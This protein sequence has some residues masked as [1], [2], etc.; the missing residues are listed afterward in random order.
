MV[1][2]SA[3]TTFLL[4]GFEKMENLKYSFFLASF[5]LYLLILFGNTSLITVIVLNENLYKPKY[6]FVCNLCLNGLCTSTAIFPKL[7]TDIISEVKT[8]SQSG[9]LIQ[10]LFETLSA[11]NEMSLLAVMA[12]DRYVSICNPL[13]YASVMTK[14]RIFKVCYRASHGV[15]SKALNTCMTHFLL[16]CMYLMGGSLVFI[17][18]RIG[19]LDPLDFV[20]LFVSLACFMIPPL[21]NPLIY[22]IRTQDIRKTLKKLI[23]N[24]IFCLSAGIKNS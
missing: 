3:G 4:T 5:V 7:M 11:F 6:I 12:Y 14:T 19:G 22:G 23:A 13:R 18:A 8:I 17:Q 10:I 24:K 1:N 20:H 15:K 2:I 9:C 16:L 21:F